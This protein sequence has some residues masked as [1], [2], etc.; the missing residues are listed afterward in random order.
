ML[1]GCCK[2]AVG[3]LWEFYRTAVWM[4]GNTN[5]TPKGEG[6]ALKKNWNV[7]GLLLHQTNWGEEKARELSEKLWVFSKI[8]RDE[9]F[10][11]NNDS[12]TNDMKCYEGI[13]DGSILKHVCFHADFF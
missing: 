9:A 4:V 13:R 3:I 6:M 2:E 10:T 8:F 7:K 11:S 5:Q 1:L 12:S